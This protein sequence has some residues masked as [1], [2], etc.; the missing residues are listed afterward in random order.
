VIRAGLLKLGGGMLGK[1]LAADRGHRGQRV[2]CGHGHEAEF[3]GYR[4]KDIDT[5]LGPVT[6]N[7]AWSHCQQCG[8]GLAPGTPGSAPPGHRCR[9]GWPR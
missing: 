2:P 9:P 4:D 1:L 5:V 6:L 3:A 8:H 7:R